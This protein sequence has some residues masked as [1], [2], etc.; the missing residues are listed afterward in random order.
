MIARAALTFLLLV[1]CDHAR[2]TAQ[3]DTCDHALIPQ[4]T[5]LEKQEAAKSSWFM[6]VSESNYEQAKTAAEGQAY[7]Q[8]F[9]GSYASFVAKRREYFQNQ[10]LEQS[11]D[12]SLADYKS[13]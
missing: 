1:L 11:Y 6:L 12:K 2:A 5:S 4:I 7:F 3:G 10:G 8:M 9:S 13:F